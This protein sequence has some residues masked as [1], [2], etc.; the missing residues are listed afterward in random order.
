MTR[1]A[2]VNRAAFER[3]VAAVSAATAE[4]L[5]AMVATAPPHDRAIE[6]LRARERRER[7][8]GLLQGVQNAGRAGAPAGRL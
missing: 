4:M 1:P 6:R 7:H 2:Q 3:A 5:A 8:D